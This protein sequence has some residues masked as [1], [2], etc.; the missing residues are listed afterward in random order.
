MWGAQ[1]VG[2]SCH[3][4]I[5]PSALT[6]PMRTCDPDSNPPV[7]GWGQQPATAT[8]CRRLMGAPGAQITRRAPIVRG[9]TLSWGGHVGRAHP[10]VCS[11]RGPPNG[12]P[13]SLR[14]C[15]HAFGES[16]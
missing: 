12:R 14:A 13:L 1:A 11:A 2:R 16:S 8:A 9:R 6:S 4:Y 3:T 10:C 5:P 7:A 15:V